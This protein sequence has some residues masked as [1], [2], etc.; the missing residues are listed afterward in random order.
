MEDTL[1][2][3]VVIFLGLAAVF[4]M[5]NYQ[6]FWQ[7]IEFV[8]SPPPAVSR[9]SVAEDRTEEPNR[10]AIPALGITASIVYAEAAE[11]KIFRAA[12]ANGV[13]H[14]PGTAEFGAIGNAYIFGHSSDFV[15]SKGDY[16]T[17]FALLPKIKTGDEITV[18][19]RQGKLHVYR[20]FETLVV[21][22]SD[23]HY[24]SQETE[25][26]A[27]LT[28]QTSYPIGTALKRFLARAELVAGN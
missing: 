10:L 24:L 17:V 25:G 20:V 4:V 19:D 23:T 13:A 26:R 16:K 7:Q 6:Y 18:S 8:I 5:L 27:L 1:K 3:V 28:V 14:Y 15:F 11:E 9:L 2:R 21:A 12:L 22:P